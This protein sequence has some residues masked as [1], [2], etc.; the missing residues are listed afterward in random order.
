MIPWAHEIST[1]SPLDE[2]S[3]Q[4]MTTNWHFQGPGPNTVSIIFHSPQLF[5]GMAS[6]LRFSRQKALHSFK[7]SLDSSRHLYTR[8][9]RFISSRTLYETALAIRIPCSL[10]KCIQKQIGWNIHRKHV[11]DDPKQLM[12]SYDYKPAMLLTAAWRPSQ[13]WNTHSSIQQVV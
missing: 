13:L 7:G 10:S 3:S 5:C 9:L 2:P 11:G 6:P 4:R 12:E 8:L 1:Q